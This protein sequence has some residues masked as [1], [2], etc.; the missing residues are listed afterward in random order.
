MADSLC[1]LCRG[2][3]HVRNLKG[4]WVRCSCVKSQ[5]LSQF[6]KP[7]VSS[8]EDISVLDMSQEPRPLKDWLSIGDYVWFR[9]TVWRSLVAYEHTGLRYL[10]DDAYRLV[11]IYLGNDPEISRLRDLEDY[12][13]VVIVL[14]LADLPNRML[15]PLVVQ[16]L[17]QRRMAARP[18]WLYS[19]T[20]RLRERYGAE[21]DDAVAP[22]ITGVDPL[23]R[24]PEMQAPSRV[25]PSD[26]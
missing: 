16:L 7:K 13:L 23:S 20:P 5:L 10:Y 22:M 19:S 21:L 9:R 15:A 14:G 1:Q 12:D 4:N 25:N 24:Q 26:L 18:T 3:K 2:A 8:G 17:T 6:I 11:E